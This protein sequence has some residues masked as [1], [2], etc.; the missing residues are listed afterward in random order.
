MRSALLGVLLI[1]LWPVGLAHAQRP[2][3]AV[4]DW[5]G[6]G[7][8][9]A[10]NQAVRGLSSAAELVPSSDVGSPSSA[11]EY[12]S[13]AAE[14]G[15]R[16]FVVGAIRRAGRRWRAD[17]RVFDSTGEQIVEKT[18]QARSANALGA[19]LRRQLWPSIREAVGASP[20]PGPGT[21]SP[22]DEMATP[23]ASSAG[24]PILVMTFTGPGSARARDR[25]IDALEGANVELVTSP[26]ATH[27]D[28]TTS[29][30]RR[31]AAREL[32]LAGIIGG[33]VAH[34]GDDYE[35]SVHLYSGEDGDEEK[36]A[37]FEG[38]S[39]D[40]LLEDID[41]DLVSELGDDIADL[42]PVSRGGGGSSRAGGSAYR[43]PTAT[44]G[45]VPLAIFFE[46]GLL[47][48]TWSY[49]DDLNMALR[50]YSLPIGPFVGIRAQWFPAAHFTD[51][52]I[53]NIGVDLRAESAFGL[54]STDSQGREYPT[55]MYG[56]SLGLRL[57]LPIDTHQISAVIGYSTTEFRIDAIDPE[58]PMPEVPDIDYDI[59]RLG[60][61]GR[62]V[63][64][65]LAF[66]LR[67]SYL[68]LAG[69]GPLSSTQ[70]FPHNSGGGME[71]GATVGFFL[72][73]F[74]EIRA[75]VDYR[76]YFFAMK[77]EVG[78][79]DN[80]IAGGALDE[81]WMGNLGVGVYFDAD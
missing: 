43:P 39:A 18:F 9:R 66:E 6:A 41:G 33:E 77:P 70:W 64:G 50:A 28:L 12:A 34:H 76:R 55:S 52:F 31:D 1:A 73:D 29:S 32:G 16:A 62:L 21:A 79:P 49:N 10:R 65:P 44:A 27:A 24:G 75:S 23:A 61:E 37:A 42:E 59:L 80:R 17:V 13:V 5:S 63:F 35:A 22:P 36:S 3:V 53:S 51:S 72:L 60:A 46:L 11:E 38:A 26:S 19:E 56:V 14:H 47:N 78:D 69:T 7:S 67:A 40:A 4:L 68:V 48:R 2:R 45:A 54:K 71:A 15:V 74:L 8:A 30:G 57:R 25:V 81:Y 20:D 58:T